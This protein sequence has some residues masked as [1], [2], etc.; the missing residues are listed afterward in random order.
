MA[1]I[2]ETKKY[3]HMLVKIL[4]FVLVLCVFKLIESFFEIK[5]MPIIY[6]LTY[7]FFS[8]FIIGRL[9]NTVREKIMILI[10]LLMDTLMTIYLLEKKSSFFLKYIILFILLSGLMVF[11]YHFF[12]KNEKKKDLLIFLMP[13]YLLFVKFVFIITYVYL[14]LDEFNIF[15][16]WFL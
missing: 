7:L 9:F 2:N 15:T 11:I 12:N 16:L 10:Y 4:V 3:L 5:S 14:H 1:I 6:L 13:F 8:F